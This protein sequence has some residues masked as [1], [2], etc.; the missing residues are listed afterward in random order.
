[1]LC[2]PNPFWICHHNNI[3]DEAS[4]YEILSALLETDIS[5]RNMGLRETKKTLYILNI[6]Y[7]VIGAW[8]DC[9]I[10]TKIK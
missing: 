2:F 5:D 6:Y 8:Y 3:N 7:T 4:H 1:M 9:G 10:I